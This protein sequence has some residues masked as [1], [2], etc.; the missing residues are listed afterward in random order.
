[1]GGAPPARTGL[2][3][4]AHEE[5]IATG[6]H[7]QEGVGCLSGQ[8][9]AARATGEVHLDAGRLRDLAAGLLERVYKARPG[10][11][12]YEATLGPAAE[13]RLRPAREAGRRELAA[14]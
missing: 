11:P 6:G 4:V 8:G 12:L 1:M 3:G 2:G 10:D 7:R 13:P 5:V 9:A 14:V